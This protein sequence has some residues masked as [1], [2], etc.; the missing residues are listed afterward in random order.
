MIITR[1]KCVKF[2]M[3]NFLAQRWSSPLVGLK[4][5]RFQVL[6]HQF[7]PRGQLGTTELVNLEVMIWLMFY[8]GL[9]RTLKLNIQSE[10]TILKL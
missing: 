2:V 1:N 4:K 6:F 3:Y 9:W 7:V 8:L 10:T 5:M